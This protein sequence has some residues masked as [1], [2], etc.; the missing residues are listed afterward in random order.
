MNSLRLFILLI[1]FIVTSHILFQSNTKA[2][3]DLHHAGAV[4][5]LLKEYIITLPNGGNVVPPRLFIYQGKAFS[6]ACPQSGI[7]SPAYCPGDHTVYLETRMGDQVANNYGDFGALSI[8][9]HEF[10]HAYMSKLKIHPEGKNGEL[11]AD[12]FAGGF[13]R[14]VEQKKLLETGDIEEARTTFASVGDHEVYHNDHHGTPIE[15]LQAFNN[16]YSFGFKAP[17]SQQP[18]ETPS[19]PITTTDPPDKNQPTQNIP[20]ST[21]NENSNSTGVPI[22]GLSIALILPILIIAVVITLINKAKDDD[23]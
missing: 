15:R 3:W 20:P 19:G 14:F 4:E 1:S 17:G 2:A 22:L 16:G 13:A 23:Y 18:N 6:R 21:T 12:A 5:D 10:G 9:A 7:E 11:A 8:I